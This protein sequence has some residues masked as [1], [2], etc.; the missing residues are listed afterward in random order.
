MTR[1]QARMSALGGAIAV[2]ALAAVIGMFLLW[3]SKEQPAAIMPAAPP[4]ASETAGAGGPLALLPTPRPVPV[5]DF[6]DVNG[7]PMTLADFGGR[8]VLLNVWATWCAPCRKEMPTLDRLEQKM[9]GPN[10]QVVPLSI[11]RQGRGVVEKFYREVGIKALGIY[12][13]QSSKAAGD[14]GVV[15]LP[16]TLLIDR[17]G[18]ELGRKIGPDDWDGPETVTLI[19][20]AV[21]AA[22]NSGDGPQ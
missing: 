8:V 14:L 3:R 20:R 19:R 4:L 21:A 13:D 17:K 6:V 22:T 15:G 7:K 16:T 1:M 5:V 10:F 18:H 2:L 9:G 12:L 11:D